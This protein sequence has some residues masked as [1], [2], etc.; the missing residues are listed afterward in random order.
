MPKFKHT[1]IVD[2]LLFI[3]VEKK[4]CITCG[5]PTEYIDY[6]S[7]GRIC[8]DECMRNFYNIVKQSKSKSFGEFV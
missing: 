6:F 3:S 4:P 1:D 7:N 5:E 8:S 2:K